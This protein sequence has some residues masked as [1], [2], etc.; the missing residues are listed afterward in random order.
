M[1]S[2]DTQFKSGAEWKGNAG[3]RPKGTM[4]DYLAKKFQEM[5]EEEKEE[6]LKK[7]KVTGKDQIEFGEGKARQDI[8][9][10]TEKAML[11]K[12]DE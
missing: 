10:N 2:E 9:H 4:K 5:S 1:P 8:E 11:I 3:G 6:F 7:H 12:I